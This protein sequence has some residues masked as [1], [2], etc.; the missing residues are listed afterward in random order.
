MPTRYK[1]HY[2][3]RQEMK[4]VSPEYIEIIEKDALLCKYQN[5]L[6]DIIG[7]IK[8][9]K[10][11]DAKWDSVEEIIEILNDYRLAKELGFQAIKRKK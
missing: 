4:K 3:R 5:A 10:K 7:A 1:L 9:Y 11:S 2:K 8:I 6:D